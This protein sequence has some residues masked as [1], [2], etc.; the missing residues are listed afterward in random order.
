LIG[1][2]GIAGSQSATPLWQVNGSGIGKEKGAP[3]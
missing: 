2:G 1:C 3:E